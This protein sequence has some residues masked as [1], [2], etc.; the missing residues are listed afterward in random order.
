ME[1]IINF[2]NISRFD[3][4]NYNLAH[5]TKVAAIIDMNKS[6]EIPF[7]DNKKK[8]K[9]D[10]YRFLLS[11]NQNKTISEHKINNDILIP[12]SILKKCGE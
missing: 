1:N 12:R 8:N 2:L 3:Y 6:A 4:S 7:N 11:Q 9:N 5:S 10:F